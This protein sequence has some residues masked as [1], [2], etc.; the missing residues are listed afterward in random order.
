MAEWLRRLTANQISSEARVRISPSSVCLLLPTNSETRTPSKVERQLKRRAVGTQPFD[1]TGEGCCLVY[2]LQISC[3]QTSLATS[4]SRRGESSFST[5]ILLGFM[6]RPRR[7]ATSDFWWIVGLALAEMEITPLCISLHHI[8][9]YNVALRH[10]PA[11]HFFK[12]TS[13]ISET[14]GYQH[15]FQWR[16]TPSPA[17]ERK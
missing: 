5:G 6:F 10:P 3:I 9:A 11:Y 1:T 7:I 8:A 15:L 16:G 13:L 17:H 12:D 14:I 2:D 4:F